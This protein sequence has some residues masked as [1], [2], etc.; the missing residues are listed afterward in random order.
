MDSIS[1]LEELTIY[2]APL[3]PT[4][5]QLPKL[6][7]IACDR[8]SE[9]GPALASIFQAAPNLERLE[10]F[11]DWDT[12]DDLA[13]CDS[14][15]L[16][17]L[18]HLT[19]L[20]K[21]EDGSGLP[22][23]RTVADF[24]AGCSSVLESVTFGPFLP[25]QHFILLNAIE[26]PLKVIAMNV[27]LEHSSAPSILG[28]VLIDAEGMECASELEGWN[29]FLN[30]YPHLGDSDDEPVEGKMKRS[31][32]EDEEWDAWKKACEERGIK[33]DVSDDM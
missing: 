4:K 21:D 5:A 16:E 8:R 9:A 2:I 18:K 22:D 19:L 14:T 6:R 29:V 26:A 24:V 1:A 33:L 28:A 7:S 13:D 25:A 17:N 31:Y 10:L 3:P 12:P 23:P 15:V 27:I 30:V 20:V 32:L 11:V